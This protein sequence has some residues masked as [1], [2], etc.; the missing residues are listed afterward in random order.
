MKCEE[1]LGSFTLRELLVLFKFY[2]LTDLQHLAG[3][4]IVHFCE[5][6]G[7]SSIMEKGSPKPV[8]HHLARAILISCRKHKIILTVEWNREKK[9]SCN[10]WILVLVDRGSSWKIIN[11][12]LFQCHTSRVSIPLL[13]T[14]WPPTILDSVFATTH[15]PSS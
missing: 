3:L 6:C 10:S 11:W 2:V 4:N 5:N 14:P 9:K 12:I 15:A 7:V 13:L 8:L 1:M